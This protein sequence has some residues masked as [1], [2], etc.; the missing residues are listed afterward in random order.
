MRL[1]AISTHVDPQKG[2]CLLSSGVPEPEVEV[3]VEECPGVCV[4]ALRC[5]LVVGCDQYLLA[6]VVSFLDLDSVPE[7]QCVPVFSI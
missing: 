5:Y 4:L 2:L 7:F 1:R 3:E 6:S